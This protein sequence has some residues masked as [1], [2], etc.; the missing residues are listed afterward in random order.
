M[1][2]EEHE[3]NIIFMVVTVKKIQAHMRVHK[4]FEKLA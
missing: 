4:E 2:L 3:T 1:A